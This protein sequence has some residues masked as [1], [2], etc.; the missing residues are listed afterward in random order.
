MIGVCSVQE[1][2]QRFI[3]IFNQYKVEAKSIKEQI[4]RNKVTK[5][6]TSDVVSLLF[7]VPKSLVDDARTFFPSKE[8]DP[9]ENWKRAFERDFND[10]NN[11]LSRCIFLEANGSKSLRKPRTLVS[12]VMSTGTPATKVN[13]VLDGLMQLKAS[14]KQL[15]FEDDFIPVITNIER[16]QKTIIS[17]INKMWKNISQNE[18]DSF[19]S[20]DECEYFDRKQK[21]KSSKETEDLLVAM[22][23]T[24][25]GVIAYGITDDKTPSPLN[26]K[27]RDGIQ[28]QITNICRNNIDPPMSPK[29]DSKVK[30]HDIGYIFVYVP[31]AIN[32]LHS[33]KNGQTLKRVGSNNVIMKQSEIKRFY[34][35]RGR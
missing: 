5:K 17:P 29:F 32:V 25:G 4:N 27:Q 18:L 23:N 6:R 31:K 14:G 7:D 2:I 28:N 11:L 9:F 22:S 20:V 10:L 35:K 34:E 12:Q 21:M 1:E 30:E 15:I 26:N 33:T 19:F 16:T 13:R 3:S 8:T 24:M